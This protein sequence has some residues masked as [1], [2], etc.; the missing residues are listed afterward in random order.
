MCDASRV[1]GGDPHMRE[2]SGYEYVH[3]T[4]THSS[5]RTPVIISDLQYLYRAPGTPI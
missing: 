5:L 4:Y 1:L 3:V 2:D